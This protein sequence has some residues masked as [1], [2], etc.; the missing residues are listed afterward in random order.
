[1]IN[2]TATARLL[3]HLPANLQKHLAGPEELAAA[4]DHAAQTGSP[5]EVDFETFKAARKRLTLD[6]HTALAGRVTARSIIA[7]C[8]SDRRAA[9]KDAVA[10]N[11]NLPQ[12]IAE[13]LLDDT[14]AEPAG[15]SGSGRWRRLADLALRTAS[16]DGTRKLVDLVT[17]LAAYRN[18]G[19]DPMPYDNLS[20]LLSAAS[21]EDLARM[22]AKDELRELSGTRPVELLARIARRGEG[23]PDLGPA[24]IEA[25]ERETGGPVSVGWARISPR[26]AE[27]ERLVRAALPHLPRIVED[28][29]RL[30]RTINYLI[31]MNPDAGAE[32]FVAAIDLLEEH[33]LPAFH[34]T[35]RA[36]AH[37]IA[38]SMTYCRASGRKLVIGVRLAEAFSSEVKAGRSGDIAVLMAGADMLEFTRQALDH[39][40]S[41][42]ASVGAD[43]LVVLAVCDPQQKKLLAERLKNVCIDDILLEDWNIPT[44]RIVSAS[45]AVIRVVSGGDTPRTVEALSRLAQRRSGGYSRTSRL[46]SDICGKLLEDGDIVFAD[47]AAAG[48]TVLGLLEESIVRGDRS[49]RRM[50]AGDMRKAGKEATLRVVAAA[51]VAARS[52]NMRALKAMRTHVNDPEV[53]AGAALKAGL[54]R[55]LIEGE[56]HLKPGQEVMRELIS[57]VSSYDSHARDHSISAIVLASARILSSTGTIPWATDMAELLPAQALRIWGGEWSSS[58]EAHILLTSL[59][60]GPDDW[61]DAIALLDSWEGTIDQLARTLKIVNRGSGERP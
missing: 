36:S 43:L 21:A 7:A 3:P 53:L 61:Q 33:T 56:L 41:S 42:E 57:V 48:E 12:D 27:S 23:W 40:A 1:M 30:G 50:R 32:A 31:E 28:P 39:L 51:L 44:E 29:A 59:G 22:F 6:A 45:V 52:G 37:L 2:V 9:V 24:V 47:L 15:R 38:H 60:E 10:R 55:E 26:T 25:I 5:L 34:S 18:A 13:R 49:G 54:V 4:L 11:P 14:L 19:R 8:A 20:A 17:A 58:V 46:V 16:G 35:L